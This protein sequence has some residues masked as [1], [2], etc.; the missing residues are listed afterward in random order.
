MQ[1]DYLKNVRDDQF[2][3]LLGIEIVEAAPGHAVVEL[4]VGEKHLNGIGIVQGGVIF[5]LADYAFAVA[6]NAGAG[7]TVG[8]NASISYY[9]APKGSRIRAEASEE[10]AGKKLCG[11]KV[12]VTDED[13]ELV[14][15]FSGLGYRKTLA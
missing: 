8:V 10:S 15:S 9:R 7:V 11:Y 13:G 3:R 4:H 12:V 2:A 14:A 1:Q 6:S 5:T